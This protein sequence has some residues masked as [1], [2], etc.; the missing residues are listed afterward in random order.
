MFYNL[1]IILRNLRLSS[2]YSAINIDGLAIGI[3]N[4]RFQLFNYSIIHKS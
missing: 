1:K 3:A 4:A 2:I